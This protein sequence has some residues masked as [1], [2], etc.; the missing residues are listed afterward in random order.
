MDILII[1][2]IT[3]ILYIYI[4]MLQV[5]LSNSVQSCQVRIYKY[6]IWNTFFLFF[7]FLTFIYSIPLFLD[8]WLFFIFFRKIFFIK[9]KVFV[10]ARWKSFMQLGSWKIDILIAGYFTYAYIKPD[11]SCYYFTTRRLMLAR[12]CNACGVYNYCIMETRLAVVV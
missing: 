9:I 1:L 2:G 7:R 10:C 4:Y 5:S 3:I 12:V 11:I 8:T 6:I